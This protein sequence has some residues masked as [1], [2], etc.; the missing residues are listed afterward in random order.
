MKSRVIRMAGATALVV[1]L[2]IAGV[3][4][5]EAKPRKK[6]APVVEVAPVVTETSTSDLARWEASEWDAVR[7]DAVRWDAVRWAG[8]GWG[9]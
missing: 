4:P 6:P 2:S 1:G 7:W 9:E 8:S 5:A 3:S